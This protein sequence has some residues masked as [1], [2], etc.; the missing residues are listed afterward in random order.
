MVV[1][2]GKSRRQLACAPWPSPRVTHTCLGWRPGF[3]TSPG[4]I[5]QPTTQ[6]AQ[7]FLLAS[8]EG[9]V[10]RLEGWSPPFQ[11]GILPAHFTQHPPL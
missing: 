6:G 11:A 9:G 10:G 4:T 7:G 8:G 2:L 3:G 1:H 5:I